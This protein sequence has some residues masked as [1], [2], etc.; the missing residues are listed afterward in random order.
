[1]PLKKVE[2]AIRKQV[3]DSTWYGKV[4]FAVLDVLPLPNV[5]EVWKA[6]QKEMPDAP[7]KDKVELF[8]VKIDGLRTVVA[9]AIS[10]ASYYHLA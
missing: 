1:M 5:H 7:M 3:T 2:K 4:L 9:I 8:W 6:V 10:L